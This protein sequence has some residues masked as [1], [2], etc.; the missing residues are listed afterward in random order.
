[1][2]LLP[3]I[4]LHYRYFF[5]GVLLSGLIGLALEPLLAATGPQQSKR[6]LMLFSFRT[7]L[8]VHEEIDRG[9]RAA[10]Q[11]R[12]KHP[13]DIEIE[14][15]DLT[16]FDEAAYLDDLLHLL[17]RKYSHHQLDAV[18]PVFDPAVQFVLKHGDSV[19]PGVPVVFAAEY[20]KI[21]DQLS[22]KPH[23]TGVMISPDFA[24]ILELA[25]TLQPQTRQVMVVGG[26]ADFDRFLMAWA[27]E[28]FAPWEEK[29]ILSYLSDLSLADLQERV[30]QLPPHTI[31]YYLTI[32]RDGTGQEFVPRD[33]LKQL[34]EKANVPVYG[35]YDTLL[36]EGIVGGPLV[37]MQEQ[38]RLAGE[39]TAQILNGARPEQIPPVL[40]PNSLRFDWRQLRRWRISEANLPSGSIVH[41]REPSLWDRY[42]S[43]IIG[44]LTLLGLQSGLIGALLLHR[45]RRQRAEEG[46]RERLRFE[47]VLSGLS[48]AFV[49][50][51][52]DQ[53]AQEINAWLAKLLEILSLERI[54]VLELSEDKKQF[55]TTHSNTAPGIAGFPNQILTETLPWFAR[56]VSQGE[57]LAYSHLPEDLPTE[58]V[59]EK[60]YCRQEGLKSHIS[61]P[62]QVGGSVLGV[63]TFSKF[64]EYVDWGRYPTARLNLVAEI[65]AN[66]LI[67]QK[68]EENLRQAEVRYR[69]VADF[70]YDWEYWKNPDGSLN[71]VSPACERISGHTVAEFLARPS[72]FEEIL[73]PEDREIWDRHQ[74]QIQQESHLSHPAIQFRLQRKDGDIRWL[75][76]VCQPVYGRQGEFLGFRASNR[77]ITGRKQTEIKEQQHRDELAHVMRVATLGELTASLA[78]EFNQPLNAV[79]NNA[80]AGLRFLHREEPDLA[81]V[82]A[83]LQDI[84]RDGKRASAVIQR[85]RGF[86]KP[87]PRRQEAVKVNDVVTEAVALLENELRTRHITLHLHLAPDLPPAQGDYTQLQQVV[88]NLF[89]NALEAMQG[90][91]PGPREIQITTALEYPDHLS[92]NVRD[93]GKGLQPEEVEKIFEPF[94]SKKTDGMGLGLSI[95]RSIMAAHGGKLWA[96]QNPDRGATLTFTLPRYQE[97]VP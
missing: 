63:I 21:V 37:D 14:Y 72:L 40:A 6:V 46:L 87:G 38:G 59:Q 5:L 10:L 96:S 42:Q 1:M 23:M 82:T 7:I 77:D 28:A 95:S 22:L 19:F 25:L 17:R 51:P 18:I 91:G 88:L 81:E 94:Y 12:S 80:Q 89:L 11:A 71:Y 33:V 43:W 20:K 30:A 50:L 13:V 4:R 26:T 79:L 55:L 74:A 36:G 27:R 69:I 56:T 52:S 47:E 41:F 70:T 90:A 16:R 64:R 2:A 53:I 73:V 97:D 83:A 45:A 29:V 84:V 61:L 86:L 31:V 68:K 92:V 85:L 48:A 62:L 67:R 9:L 15:L 66:A 3:E 35:L 49:T 78:H 32:L 93:S 58:A 54:T 57:P 65:F 8:P 60:E 76:H 75:E 44:S 24:P 34:A 39:I